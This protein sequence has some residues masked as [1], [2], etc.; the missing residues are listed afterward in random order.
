MATIQKRGPWQWQAKVRK[1]GVRTTRTFETKA[2]AEDWAAI[3]ESEIVRNVFV[4]RSLAE[5]TTFEEVIERFIKE[6]VPRH[7]GGQSETLRLKRFVREEAAIAAKPMATLKVSDFEAYR[8]KRLEKI[9]PGSIKRELGLLQI[10]IEY[11]RRDL[12]LLENPLKDVKRPR[13]NDK[14]DVRLEPG[15]EEKLL[16]ALD[17]GRNPWAKTAV[18]LAIET[19]MRRGELLELRWEHVN[20]GKSVAHLPDTKNGYSRDV[21][22]SPRAKE[23]LQGMA[24]SIK[25]RVL[26]LSPDALKKC[27]E[28]A[29]IK[30]ELEHINFHDLRHEATSRLFEAGWNIMEVSAVTGHKDLQSLKRYTQLRAED[31]AKKMQD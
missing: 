12:G 2:E 11:V 14:R 9:K 24:H 6:E 25:G 20:L 17:E 29:R 22:L 8:D 31:L 4:D 1:K 10:V 28:R 16:A 18:I 23:M 26:P 5:R 21:P 27:F 13:V 3:I 15:D 19:A 30:A 7:K